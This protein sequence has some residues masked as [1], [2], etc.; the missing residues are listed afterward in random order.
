MCDMLLLERPLCQHLR[1]L[2]LPSM[3]DGT[4][5]DGR[6]TKSSL[7]DVY[8]GLMSSSTSLLSCQNDPR[9]MRA[10]GQNITAKILEENLLIFHN[11]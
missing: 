11:L 7:Y 2:I 3:L 4:Y 6:A 10:L 9:L 8:V 1:S 5:K